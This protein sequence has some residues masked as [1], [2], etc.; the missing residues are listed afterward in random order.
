M[1][2][3]DIV[4]LVLAVRHVLRRQVGNRGKHRIERGRMLLLLGLERRDRVLQLADLG[5][6]RRCRRL[7]L[8]LLRSTDFL[9]SG[10][11]PRLRGF[12]LLDRGAPLLVDRQQRRRLRGEP[13]PREAAVEG[14]RVFANPFDVVH[15]I[16][17]LG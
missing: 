13:A 8:V 3:L 16:E 4:V 11:A 10:V 5:H 9:R 14:D 1:M 15:G 2:V 17:A 6:Q 12:G 7:I